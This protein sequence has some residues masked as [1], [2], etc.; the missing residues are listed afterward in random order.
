MNTKVSARILASALLACALLACTESGDDPADAA[1]ITPIGPPSAGVQRPAGNIAFDYQLGGAYPPPAGVELVVRDR[2]ASP[3]AGLY[4][5]CYVNGFQTQPEDHDWWLA[6]HPD[7]ILRDAAGRPVIDP[8]WHELLLDVRTPATRAALLT[9]VGPWLEQCAADGFDAIEIDNLDTYARSG[10]LITADQAVRFMRSL[11]DR[12]HDLGLAIAQK[13][14]TDLVP[15]AAELGT[16]F[17]VV[18][19]CNRYDECDVYTAAYGARVFIIEYRQPDFERGCAGFPGLSVLL[20]DLDLVPP[21][22]AG[23]HFEGC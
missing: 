13:N 23:Y 16:D 18:E 11:T 5:V 6:A 2:T 1:P 22:E 4:N 21:D 7:L 8:D 14:A 19:E 12:T 20:R 9:V 17:A 3:A 15:R 10:G